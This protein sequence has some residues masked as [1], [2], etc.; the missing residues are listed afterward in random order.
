MTMASIDASRKDL[1][2]EFRKTP[3]GHQSVELQKMMSVMRG[4]RFPG[5]HV[6]ICTKPFKEWRLAQLSGVRGDP[7]EVVEG[8]GK[9]DSPRV[10]NRARSLEEMSGPMHRPIPSDARSEIV[11]AWDFARGMRSTRIEDASANNLH[12]QLVNLPAR[13]M[14]GCNW[15][16]SEMNWRHSPEQYG[17]IHFH[18]D[19][20]YDAGWETDFT[21][22]VPDGLPSGIYCARLDTGDEVDRIPFVVR[23]PRDR[24]T[25]DVA[26]LVPTASY[27]AYA[28]EHHGVDS[29]NPR[30]AFAF[31]GVDDEIIGDF[32]TVGGGA[33]GLEL[34][35]RDF[36]LGSPPHTLVLATSESLSPL[37]P[38]PRGGRQHRPHDFG[39]GQ[40]HGSRRPHFHG[41]GQWRCGVL[42]QLH[43]LGRQSEL[44]RLR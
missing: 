24:A 13:A 16:G 2:E 27:M 11:S 43:L 37:S 19:D 25:H 34:D 36:A 35:R 31:E 39:P 5:K 26:F 14:M 18:H 40:Q 33:A 15:T 12:G 1:V 42:S 21:L 17:A 6:L 28:N 8:V 41:D 10:A 9:I 32:G 44:E 7:P 38:L 23:P 3:V 29:D 22:A 4:E 30:A 20:I